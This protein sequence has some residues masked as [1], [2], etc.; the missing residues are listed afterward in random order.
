MEGRRRECQRRRAPKE[1]STFKSDPA[2][3]SEGSECVLLNGIFFGTL[4]QMCRSV[5][6][7]IYPFTSA[8]YMG[9]TVSFVG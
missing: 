2:P 5:A 6:H 7:V 8:V 4:G 9:V 3:R 1:A